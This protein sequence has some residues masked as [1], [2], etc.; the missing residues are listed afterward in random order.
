MSLLKRLFG[1]GGATEAPRPE[2]VLVNAYATMRHLPPLDIDHRLLG[3]RDRSDPDLAQHLQGFTGY[4]MGRGDGQM[5]SPRYYV[6]RHIQRVRHHLSFEL[7]A[8]DLPRI[9]PWAIA[10]NALLFLPDGSVRV[11][12][13]SVVVGAD[14]AADPGATMPFPADAHARRG[15]TRNKLADAA[16]QPPVGMAP[17][18]GEGELVLR[19]VEETLHRALALFYVAARAQARATGLPP[20]AAGRDELNPIGAASPTPQERMFLSDDAAAAAPLTWRY[21]AANTLLWT[22]GIDGAA[23]EASDNMIDV[24]AL[25]ASAARLAKAGDGQGLRFRP[26]GDILDALDRIWLEHW[27]VR[28]ACQKQI[29]PGAINGDVV[30]ERHVALNWLTNF[31]NDPDIAWDETDTPT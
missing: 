18:L 7:E 22:L 28:Q 23:I 13:G 1:G 26:A 8:E 17:A 14:G 21:E 9:K 2:T 30:A 31:Q 4:V 24:D 20:I 11:P 19:S 29:E 10:A 6:W 3:A 16:L 12:D 25:W 27:I 15:R 5:T